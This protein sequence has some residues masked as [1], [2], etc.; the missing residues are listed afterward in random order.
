M[1]V[2]WL[3][4]THSGRG[5]WNRQALTTAA[6]AL[7]ML[8]VLMF[9]AGINALE[10]RAKHI[11][12]RSNFFVTSISGQPIEGV[13]PLRA[14][15]A[16]GSDLDKWQQEDITTVSMRATGSNSPQLPGLSMPQEGEYYV[17]RGL[18][19]TMRLPEGESI[20]ERFGN[21]Q[22]G[23]IPDELS[24]SPDALEVIRGMSAQEAAGAGVTDIYRFPSKAEVA[25]R[26]S[27][28]M[29]VILIF[30]AT[31]LLF[32]II[33]FISIA[34]QLGSAQ[35]EKRYAA[36]RLI[37]ATRRQVVRIIAVESL[38][39]AVVGVVVGSLAY[40][41]ILPL[42]AG[43]EF[44]GMRF[45]QND[46]TVPA[47]KY[48][49]AVGLTLAF[50]LLTNW[51]SMRHVQ[52]SPL[53]VVRAQ[54]TTGQPRIWRLLPLIPGAAVFIWLALPHG[55]AWFSEN[56]PENGMPLLVLMIGLVSM[57]FGLILSGPWFTSVLSRLVARRTQ[58]AT[59]L[60]AT[61]RIS[62][63][64]KR[65]FRSVSGV[66][67]ALFVGSFYLTAMSG[68]DSLAAEDTGYSQ[69][70]PDT[71]VLAGS[72]LPKAYEA[73]LEQEPYVKAVTEIQGGIAGGVTVM[74][75]RTATEYTSIVCPRDAAFVGLNFDDAVS[76]KKWF[77]THPGDIRE[78]L[79]QDAT[80]RVASYY[81]VR[82]DSSHPI[83]QLRTFVIRTVGL[84]SGVRVVSGT[85]AQSPKPDPI[86]SE[87][88][89]LAY[90]GMLVTLCVAI[91]SLI[92]STLGGLLE[93]QRSFVTLRLGGMTVE[94]MKRTVM[95]ES[96]IPLVSVSILAA[97][98]GVWVG[99]VFTSAMSSRAEPK[100]TLLYFAIIIGSLVVAV[101]AIRSILPML[102]K[103]TRPEA[104]QTE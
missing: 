101:F 13:A 20:G 7:G 53:G 55:R 19:E 79:A 8:M 58:S 24:T 91:A 82:L 16:V 87:L 46:L 49:F 15:V 23:I 65:V 27:G 86:L 60:L 42:M 3:F 22:I 41:A 35:R 95:I 67:L 25:S 63:Q 45:W 26:Y 80:A 103:I 1:R 75:C 48:L 12:W 78:Q 84:D 62:I 94:Q 38:S 44:E 102:D 83:D 29:G 56:L 36:L 96:L 90:V 37:G 5:N 2:A 88:G 33:V 31:L 59:T 68:L 76:S 71:V 100:L 21:K 66:V 74:S 28:Q 51:W 32:P 52:L 18:A 85:Y 39:A 69:L 73:Q 11:S 10:A 97:G 70:K 40:L 50:C 81:L 54:N 43:Y 99:S 72:A 9:M 6:V 93:R 104:N 17:S 92:I 34:T 64:A 4:L 77:G 47:G 14:Q 57:M 89:A 98:L 61:K 30:G